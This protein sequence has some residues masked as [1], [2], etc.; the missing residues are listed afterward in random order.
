MR[1]I[2]IVAVLTAWMVSSAAAV[3]D[4]I[5]VEK[6]ITTDKYRLHQEQGKVSYPALRQSDAGNGSGK[7]VYRN[8][9]IEEWTYWKAEDVA[10]EKV[11]RLL[12]QRL[13]STAG[14]SISTGDRRIEVA[15]L[16]YTNK[17]SAPERSYAFDA[18]KEAAPEAVNATISYRT[19]ASSI[20]VPVRVTKMP[21]P[22]LASGAGYEMKVNISGGG[23]NISLVREQTNGSTRSQQTKDSTVH[24]SPGNNTV[25]TPYPGR[26]EAPRRSSD[27][28]GQGSRLSGIINAILSFLPL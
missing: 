6:R 25:P 22:A 5:A 13:G 1:R 24:P 20:I 19:Y 8:T 28:P 27:T 9:S 18:V 4:T 10:V 26:G 17:S 12:H 16:T 2:L 23:E 15:Y 21:A 14:I 3:N 7:T 11:R